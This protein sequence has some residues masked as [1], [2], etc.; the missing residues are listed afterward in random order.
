MGDSEELCFANWQIARVLLEFRVLIGNIWQWCPLP[1][2]LL[3]YGL[4][5]LVEMVLQR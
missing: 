5:D 3:S 4:V 1:N 2:D